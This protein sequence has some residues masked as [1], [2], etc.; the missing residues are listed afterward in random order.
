MATTYD[1]QRLE[2]EL[3]PLSTAC[4]VAYHQ[5]IDKKKRLPVDADLGRALP[6]VAVALSAVAPIHTQ[7]AAEAA[8]ELQPSELDAILFKPGDAARLD[9]LFIRRSDLHRAIEV[10]GIANDC[11]G[12]K[13]A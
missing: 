2:E 1:K 7:A 12:G 4:R 11:F 6:L 10:L 5:I 9:E 3:V 8:R 13:L